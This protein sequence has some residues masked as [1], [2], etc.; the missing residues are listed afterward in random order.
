MI[1]TVNIEINKAREAVWKA[2][3]D[4]DNCENIISSIQ[5]I[6]ILNKPASGIVGLK[7]EETREMFGKKAT[8]TMWITDAQT[9]EFYRT[10]AESHGAVYITKLTLKE[11]NGGTLLEMT[12]TAMPQSLFAKI[13]SFLMAPLIS[14]SIVKALRK[15][16]SDIKSYVEKS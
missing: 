9:N 14:K 1:V 13:L 11:L 4:I 6:N 5:K 12:F 10:R 16:L 2:I 15:D 8:E 7:W 3:T